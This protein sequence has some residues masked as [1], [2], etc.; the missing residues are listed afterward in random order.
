MLKDRPHPYAPLRRFASGLAFSAS[1]FTLLWKGTDQLEK[2]PL[3]PKLFTMVFHPIGNIGAQYPKRFVNRAEWNQFYFWMYGVLGSVSQTCSVLLA[4][5]PLVCRDDM[6]PADGVTASRARIIG[7]FQVLIGTHHAIWVTNQRWYGQFQAHKLPVPFPSVQMG[8]LCTW[9]M[10]HGWRLLRAKAGR[11]TK[12]EVQRRNTMVNMLT[13]SVSL[14]PFIF[15]VQ[16]YFVPNGSLR[17]NQAVGQ[18]TF[19]VSLAVLAY[20]AKVFGK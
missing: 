9:T 12:F 7:C 5:Q 6:T 13:T 19:G 4:R 15:M 1:V 16:N 20:D 14:Y 17:L 3:L 11:T 8:A 18:L 2:L 10:W